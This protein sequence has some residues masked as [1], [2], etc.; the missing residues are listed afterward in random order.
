MASFL[1]RASSKKGIPAGTPIYVGKT[2]PLPTEVTLIQYEGKISTITKLSLDTIE[3]QIKQ[4]MPETGGWIQVAGLQNVDVI[5]K[6]G[7]LLDINP[8]TIEDVLHTAQRAKIDFFQHYAYLVLS[9]A[10]TSTTTLKMTAFEQVSVIIKGNILVTFQES[11]DPLIEHMQVYID[12]FWSKSL[13]VDMGRLVYLLIDMIIDDYFAVIE[14]KAAVLEEIEEEIIGKEDI[15]PE[16]LYKIKRDILHL[17]KHVMNLRVVINLMIHEHQTFMKTINKVYLNDLR[18]HLTV[19]LDSIEI[20]RELNQS[21]LETYISSLEIK[22]N[23]AMR[24]LTVFASIFIPLNFITSYYGMN[25]NLPEL[26]WQHGALFAGSIM[27]LVVV[28]LLSFYRKKKW[29]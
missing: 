14:H 18:D 27:F 19:I 24:L 25:F 13:V 4:H 5:Q 3:E 26:K 8:L 29:I 11:H 21:I 28:G 2:E 7:E 1:K 23:D 15:K 22:I 6:I 9:A 17:R 10:K 16:N 20:N 12:H